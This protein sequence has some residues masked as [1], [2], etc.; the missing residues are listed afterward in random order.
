[1]LR[2]LFFVALL[3][4]AALAADT[5]FTDFAGL[6]VTPYGQQILDIAS[7]ITTLPDG[8]EI[9]DRDHGITLSG[10]F[11]RYRE[12]DFVEI[13]GARAN[14][15][16]GDLSAAMVNV[17]IAGQSLRAEGDILLSSQLLG[18]QGVSSQGVTLEAQTLRVDLEAATAVVE[19]G[20]RSVDPPFEAA[21]LIIDFER[22]EALLVGPYRYE[23]GGFTLRSS[24]SEDLLLLKTTE[25]G[26]EASTEIPAALLERL[27]LYLRA[28]R[29]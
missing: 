27:R 13:R 20:V 6:S 7:G 22:E 3:A 12:E 28:Q 4:P 1:M 10:G 29:S 14:G 9:I 8:G 17:D 19:G 26:V 11:I 2:V 23:D 25:R 5:D 24:R 16:F 21:A 15:A 18:S